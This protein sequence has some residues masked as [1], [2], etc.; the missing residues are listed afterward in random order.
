MVLDKLPI[1]SHVRLA[2]PGLPVGVT[3]L[4]RGHS[5]TDGSDGRDGWTLG[6]FFLAYQRDLEKGFIPIQ[7]ALAAKDT[8]NETSSTSDR[9][10]SPVPAG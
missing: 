8:L 9:A 6:L 3:I 5:F 1:D 2:A 4:R 10:S 7:R